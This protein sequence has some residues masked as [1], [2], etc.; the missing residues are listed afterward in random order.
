MNVPDTAAMRETRVRSALRQLAAEEVP[1]GLDLWP[2]LG[3]RVR[4]AR[5]HR[6]AGHRRVVLVAALLVALL[7]IGGTAVAAGTDMLQR[8]G[9]LL[10]SPSAVERLTGLAPTQTTADSRGVA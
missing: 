3:N 9:M 10:L 4:T 6:P 2:A 1:E 7:A 5:A 8:F